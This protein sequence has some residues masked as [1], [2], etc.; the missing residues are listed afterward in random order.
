MDPEKIEALVMFLM[1][2][3]KAHPLESVQMPVSDDLVGKVTLIMKLLEVFKH[4][5]IVTLS[6]HFCVHLI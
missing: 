6:G 4:I 2:I 3:E 5:G 1:G